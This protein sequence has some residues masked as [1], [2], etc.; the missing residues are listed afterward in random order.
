MFTENDCE[1]YFKSI[2]SDKI[3][4]KR[5]TSL[6]WMNKFKDPIINFNL[7]PPTYTEISKI[8]SKMKSSVSPCPLNQGSVI[9]FKKCPILCSHLTKIIQLAWK[10]RNFPKAWKSGVTVLAY[11][12]IDPNE[13]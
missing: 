9:A 7:Q 1:K 3:C 5:F 12:E 11:K 6:S 2:L 10:I 4:Q 13:P 8:I